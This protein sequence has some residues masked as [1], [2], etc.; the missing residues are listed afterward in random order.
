MYLVRA[1]SERSSSNS[2]ARSAL[3]LALPSCSACRREASR[4]THGRTPRAAHIA[5]AVVARAEAAAS[6]AVGAAWSGRTSD[7]A[8]VVGGSGGPFFGRHRVCQRHV[9][10]E[11]RRSTRRR[12]GRRG[13]ISAGKR[14]GDMSRHGDLGR[15]GPSSAAAAIDGTD[16]IPSSVRRCGLRVPSSVRRCGLR[17]PSSVRRCRLRA[18]VHVAPLL[19]VRAALAG[20][21]RVYTSDAADDLLAV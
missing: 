10:R 8:Q 17:V 4:L 7:G 9:S 11:T 2:R 6:A 13:V 12:V 19:T 5:A 20:G 15:D 14:D 1:L 18:A 21:W 16:C 3:A